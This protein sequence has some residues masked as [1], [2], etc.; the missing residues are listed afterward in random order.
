MVTLNLLPI[1]LSCYLITS[2][3]AVVELIESFGGL[4][5]H[6]LVHVRVD[7]VNFRIAET[8]E[9]HCEMLRDSGDHQIGGKAMA[10]II[11]TQSLHAGNATGSAPGTFEASC[12]FR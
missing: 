11:E 7:R 3:T 1:C 10:E 8:G 6:P 2:F 5:G 4:P 12:G 9:F